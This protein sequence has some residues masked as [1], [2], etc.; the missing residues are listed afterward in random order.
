[1]T[2]WKCCLTNNLTYFKVDLRSTSLSWQ[3]FRLFY[4][5]VTILFNIVTVAYKTI[6]RKR[7]LKTNLKLIVSSLLPK[8]GEDTI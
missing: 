8:R 4:S 2:L 3:H 6:V 7:V 5:N 1:M